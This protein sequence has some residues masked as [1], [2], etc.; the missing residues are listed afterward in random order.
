[1]WCDRS[2]PAGR[3]ARRRIDCSLQQSVIPFQALVNHSP[4]AIFHTDDAGAATYSSD[5]W[6]EMLGLTS[7][8]SL[9]F[10][11]Y[12]VIHP[13]DHERVLQSWRES[14]AHRAKV[15]VL[16]RIRRADGT[17]R[18]VRA[19][20]R[21]LP[22]DSG[23]SGYVAV[24]LDISDQVRAERR[25]RRNNLL[26]SAVLKSIPCGV[27]VF[28]AAGKLVLDNQQFR[29]LI[30]E[31]GDAGSSDFS[32]LALQDAL[33]QEFAQIDTD[34]AEGFEEDL[35]APL[36]RQETQPDGRVLE[37]RQASMPAGG[38][39]TT[40][41]DVS[42]HMQVLQS[43]REA[44]VAAEQATDAKAAFL[45]TMSH[46]IRTP[47]NGVIGMANLLLNTPLDAE[48]RELAEI[49][50][51]SGES[52]LVVLNDILDYSKIESGHMELEW[53]PLR[54]S[55]VL[56]NSIQ[57]LQVKAQENDVALSYH[58][59][60]MVPG[61]IY[62][63]RTR[64]QQVLV[65]LLSNAV[66]FTSHGEVKV[67][68][69]KGVSPAPKQSGEATG[70]MCLIT[71]R[72]EDT[73]TGIP[74]DTI[75]RL[76]EPF[77]QADSSTARRFGGTGLGL[78]IARRLVAAMGGSIEIE[79]EVGVGTC[80]RFSF[81]AESA[82][83]KTDL[84]VQA[85]ATLWG[86]RA[87]LLVGRR[88]DYRMLGLQMKRWGMAHDACTSPSAA[89]A[90]LAGGERFHVIIC[91]A[92]LHTSEF[93]LQIRKLH[94]KVP[95]V[96]LASAK[97]PDPA[98]ADSV[99]AVL[100]PS[101]GE[102]VLYETLLG[103]MQETDRL[104]VSGQAPSSQFDASL[105]GRIP[106]RILL[107]EDNEINCKVALRM[108]R[109]FGYEAD[110][111]RDGLEAIKAVGRQRYDLVL[112]DI[113]MPGMNGLEA[114]RF[115]AD[116]LAPGLRPRIVAMSANVMREEI[117]AA[118]AAGAA[119]YIGKPFSVSRL[120]IALEQAASNP[121]PSGSG[122]EPERSPPRGSVVAYEK[123]DVH[124]ESGIEYLQELVA[125]FDDAAWVL[126]EKMR[127]GISSNTLAAVKAAGHD[128]T[129]MAGIMGADRLMHAGL[130][131]QKAAREGDFA[132]AAEL[133]ERCEP[134][135]RETV[136]ALRKFLRDGPG[137][138]Q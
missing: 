53:T 7:D 115:I 18:H 97:H 38:T 6:L 47:M 124:L 80:V 63:D 20:A 4:F 108:L 24:A 34:I 58:V 131:L 43:L 91:Q 54:F 106:L 83:P 77:V 28:D 96:L 117:D 123:L 59:D 15:D 45:A 129:G 44:K 79:S 113:Q 71:V 99:A 90:M 133:V 50:Q 72:V 21:P 1:M 107:A 110:V 82:T 52:L 81:L 30:A 19:I 40:Y 75:D 51:H 86:K 119:D 16:F 93:A 111:A 9:G 138:P 121:A 76:F 85:S 14:I 134:Q 62:G 55:E 11:W 70:D 29:S 125:S 116:N 109:N 118:L 33:S 112:M 36:V 66:K 103:T 92:A 25:L 31:S 136:A 105:A 26:L 78:A 13:L 94:P 27:S 2:G 17:R 102:S 41:T 84:A 128:L 137:A 127:N 61:L 114:T 49:I 65:N 57:L 89:L 120:R 5:A 37:V 101:A 74:T 42:Q 73:G 39:V 35:G 8:E 22:T 60:A 10:G 67:F 88:T 126:M 32:P 100:N 104:N 3:K 98:L 135:I 68:V 64:L 23:A 95:V 87:L 56:D 122:E 12:S 130:N 132:K 69:D 48:Q 46:E